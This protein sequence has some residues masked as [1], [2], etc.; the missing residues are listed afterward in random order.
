MSGWHALTVELDAHLATLNAAV[1]LLRR[2]NLPT[3][4]VTV[5]PAPAEGRM[6]LFAMIE[7]DA[8]TAARITELFRKM[9]GVHDVRATAAD[10]TVQRELV[11]VRLRPA[12][13]DAYAELLDVLGLYHASVVEESG[14]GIVAE[15]SGPASFV[16]SC[17]RALERF[18]VVDVARSGTLAV[19]RPAPAPAP[20]PFTP[21]EIHA[22]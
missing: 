10:A 1:G 5:G 11:L 8:G 16:L 15:V 6:R 13:G 9:I 4:D 7:T 3:K 17:L 18:G 2:R 22:S 12:G 19:E 20:L 14:D 21:T